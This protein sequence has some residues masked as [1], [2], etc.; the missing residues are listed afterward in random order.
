[1]FLA[2]CEK[3]SKQTLKLITG[4]PKIKQRIFQ[5][6]YLEYVKPIG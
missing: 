5:N 1:M 6:T 2:L 4:V 3:I